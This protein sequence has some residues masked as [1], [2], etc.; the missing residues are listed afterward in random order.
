[1]NNIKVYNLQKYLGEEISVSILS[2]GMMKMAKSED[3]IV[4]LIG[5][6]WSNDELAHEALSPAACTNEIPGFGKPRPINKNKFRLLYSKHI[7]FRNCV[8]FLLFYPCNIK[9]ESRPL[10][11]ASRDEK[12]VSSLVPQISTAHSLTRGS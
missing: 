2:L 11:S 6:L 8:N 3:K 10:F 12:N 9:I 1:M 5:F 7:Y 4:L